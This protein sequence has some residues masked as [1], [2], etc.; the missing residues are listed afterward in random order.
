ML[1]FVQYVHP[2]SGKNVLRG[3]HF[4]KAKLKVTI[5][6]VLRSEIFDVAVVIDKDS[7]S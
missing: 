2:H 4:Q 1:D 3:L 6:R 5:V 7:Q